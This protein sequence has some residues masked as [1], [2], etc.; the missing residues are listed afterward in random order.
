MASTEGAN[1]VKD[2]GRAVAQIE[3]EI[4]LATDIPDEALEGAAETVND[5]GATCFTVAVCT[6]LAACP[7]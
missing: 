3:A 2:T 7:S 6:G 4:I 1:A 5:G